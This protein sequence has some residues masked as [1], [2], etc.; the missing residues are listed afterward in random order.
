MVAFDGSRAACVLEFIANEGVPERSG[1]TSTS[2]HSAL[3]KTRTIQSLCGLRATSVSVA[4]RYCASGWATVSSTDD[5]IR[6]SRRQATC[7]E[8]IGMVDAARRRGPLRDS[9]SAFLIRGC[10]TRATRLRPPRSFEFRHR[11]IERIV[12]VGAPLAARAR[13]VGLSEIEHVASNVWA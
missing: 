6:N 13:F 4:L 12:V 1:P 3:R 5:G 2:D 8:T 7:V 11:T 10:P 9:H